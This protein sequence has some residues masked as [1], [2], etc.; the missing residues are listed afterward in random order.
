MAKAA[1]AAKVEPTP[2]PAAKPAKR[3]LTEKTITVCQAAD[4]LPIDELVI[5]E[6][7][8]RT[9]SRE[10]LDDLKR[11]IVEKGVYKP[12][13]VWRKGN[14]VLSGNQR[15]RA[16]EELID[17]GYVFRTASGLANTFPCVIED[18]EDEVAESILFDDNNHYGNWVEEKL[19]VAVAQ[20]QEAGKDLGKWGFTKQAVDDLL[21]D[22]LKGAADA[23]S[24]TS[25]V[26][27]HERTTGDGKPKDEDGESTEKQEALILPKSLYLKLADIFQDMAYQLNPEWRDGDS[28]VPAIEQFVAFTYKEGVPDLAEWLKEQKK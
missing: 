25:T 14:V 16:V 6:D 1:K 2:E 27:E 15:K 7:N 11:S 24:K 28:L 5:H 23:T 17:D 22:A 10:R 21:K 8:P 20:A 9:I 12:F 4:Y 19:Q 13:L 3:K 26:G 18:V